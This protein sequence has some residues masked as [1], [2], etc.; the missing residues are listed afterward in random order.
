MPSTSPYHELARRHARLHRI[1][2]ASAILAWDRA[3]LMPPGGVGARA[4]A[5][6]ELQLLAR[7]LRTDPAIGAL[8]DA[9]AQESLGEWETANLREMRRDW[10][11]ANAV[12]AEIVTRR[13]MAS[14]KCELGWR[15][16]RFD[17]DWAGYLP[18]WR[19]VVALSRAEARQL[20]GTLG[21]S[22]YDALLQRFEP[23]IDSAQVSA[24]FDGLTTWLPTLIAE[25]RGR[26]GALV[27]LGK[28]DIETQRRIARSLATRLGFDFQ[29]GRLDES[30][31]P[32][33]G[34]VADDIR[35]TTRF[36]EDALLQGIN[37]TI[38]ET[39]HAHYVAGLPAA[40]REQPVG[41]A[42]SFGVHESQSL[43]LEMQLAR[44]PAFCALLSPMLIEAAGPRAA[45]E[46]TA[47]Y[48]RMTRVEPGLIRVHADEASYPLHVVAR[49]RIE[50]ALIEGEIEADDVPAMWDEQMAELLGLDTRGNYRDGCLQ[51]VHWSRGAFG[52]FPSYTLGAI[53]AAQL[54]AAMRAALGDLD[55]LVAD[56][57]FAPIFGWLATQVWSQGCRFETPELLRHATGSALDAGP[58]RAHLTVRYGGLTA[59][60]TPSR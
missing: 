11:E 58:Y 57:D 29:H 42:R 44:T 27:P 35:I 52:Y 28:V 16:Q 25:A 50:R 22:P 23:G 13:T 54:F 2:H 45:F 8:L 39:G 32:F 4:A 55:A 21:C 10:I 40:W 56:G 18:A 59:D 47:L 34:G 20:G 48:A 3:T 38:H 46:P 19:E 15:R 30:T 24:I 5:E 31:H 60:A 51:D 53:Y 33:T 41:G 14:A 43:G 37:S 12:P 1:G 36:R 17:N 9:A 7:E 6:A 49:F 26:S